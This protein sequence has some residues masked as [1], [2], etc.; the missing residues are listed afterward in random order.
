MH[1]VLGCLK[2]ILL[3]F[4]NHYFSTLKLKPSHP[5]PIELKHKCNRIL[6]KVPW[7]CRYSGQS[8]TIENSKMSW[9]LAANLFTFRRFSNIFFFFMFISF[10]LCHSSNPRVNSV[11]STQEN[12][13]PPFLLLLRLLLLSYTQ[14]LSFL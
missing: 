14:T 5:F 3:K 4:Y 11:T 2:K 13:I 7:L 6:L 10:P 8:K 1:V 9:I 12:S